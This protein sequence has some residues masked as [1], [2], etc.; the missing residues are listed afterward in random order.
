MN[1]SDEVQF[2]VFKIIW[3][4]IICITRYKDIKEECLGKTNPKLIKAVE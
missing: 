1:E 3:I 4:I 2:E